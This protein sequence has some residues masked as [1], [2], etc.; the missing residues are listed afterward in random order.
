MEETAA[1]M[2]AMSIAHSERTLKLK[3]RKHQPMGRSKPTFFAVASRFDEMIRS[4]WAM[5]DR[6]LEDALHS[7]LRKGLATAKSQM[8]I[9]QQELNDW[10]TKFQILEEGCQVWVDRCKGLEESLDSKEYQSKLLDRENQKLLFLIGVREGE[11]ANL[12]REVDHMRDT[13]DQTGRDEY[14]IPPGGF[15]R[16]SSPFFNDI[17]SSAV[18]LNKE[19]V[20]VEADLKTRSFAPSIHARSMRQPVHM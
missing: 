12:M 19:L 5:P 10:R 17:D 14:E 3:Q 18:K 9:L 4:G 8:G 13:R 1:D 15:P 7:D 6:S 11:I 2:L 16:P 20:A